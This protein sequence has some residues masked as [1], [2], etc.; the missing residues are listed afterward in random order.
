MHTSGID[1]AVVRVNAKKPGHLLPRLAASQHLF[2]LG[3]KERIRGVC[4]QDLASNV[5]GP[6]MEIVLGWQQ[7]HENV[8]RRQYA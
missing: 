4:R 7:A 1:G 6:T 3:F 8:R 2:D 5:G